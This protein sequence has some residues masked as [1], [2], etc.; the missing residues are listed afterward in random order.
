MD[1]GLTDREEA[2]AFTADVLLHRSHH[3]RSPDVR[4]SRA[5]DRLTLYRPRLRPGAAA[6]EHRQPH[7][8]DF[9]SWPGT[10]AVPTYGARE[11]LDLFDSREPPPGSPHPTWPTVP[12]TPRNSRRSALMSATLI[13]QLTDTDQG[14]P[15]AVSLPVAGSRAQPS[16]TCAASGY[17]TSVRSAPVKV[18]SVRFASV[19]SA[20][21]RS[22]S[23]RSASV[24]SARVRLTPVRSAPT[25]ITPARVA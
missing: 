15:R 7:P 22:A 18:A 6:A 20:S 8:A 23:V 19:R 11:R 24:R 9:L 5:Q 10:A 4:G 17:L 13:R 25:R 16:G 21:V 1:A 12:P 14:D 2:D 3:T